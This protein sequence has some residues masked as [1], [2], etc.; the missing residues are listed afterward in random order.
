MPFNTF[1]FLKR[2]QRSRGLRKIR[3]FNKTMVYKS[4]ALGTN[5]QQVRESKE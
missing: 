1:N 5:N 4:Q 3:R 2:N